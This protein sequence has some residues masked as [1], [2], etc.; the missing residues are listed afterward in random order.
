M[1]RKNISDK[2]I[3]NAVLSFNEAVYLLIKRGF[4]VLFFVN[5]FGISLMVIVDIDHKKATYLCVF[6]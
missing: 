5:V 2:S 4:N 3:L 6:I 1:H